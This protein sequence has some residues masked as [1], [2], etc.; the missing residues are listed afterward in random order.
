MIEFATLSN[1][2]LL[3][4]YSVFM[5]ELRERQIIRTKNIV[6]DLGEYYAINFYNR[7]SKLP[8]L[9]TAP[10]GTQNIDAISREGKRYS[11]KSTTTKQT[12]NFSG[13]LDP[14]STTLE[15]Q[16]FEFVIVV[17]LDDNL[18]LIRILELDWN[19]FL[20]CKQ[21]NKTTRTWKLGISKNL[22]QKSKIL[23]EE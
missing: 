12:G 11:I 6:G 5:K 10:I 21:W 1:N 7:N 2:E 14:D 8:K 17:E 18:K 22:L 13:L 15:P 9:K 3:G 23:F 20:D 19:A 16:K 4:F